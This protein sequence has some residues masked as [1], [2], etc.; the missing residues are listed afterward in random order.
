MHRGQKIYIC[1]LDSK[2]K[3]AILYDIIC[4]QSKGLKGKT[5]FSYSALE[6]AAI[7]NL[8]NLLGIK[9]RVAQM[10]LS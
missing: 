3:A 2:F 10:K 5:N 4:I 1:T 6:L 7:L 8:R 9:S